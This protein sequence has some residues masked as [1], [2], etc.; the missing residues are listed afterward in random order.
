MNDIETI[1]VV[2]IIYG[3]VWLGR[4]VETRTLPPVDTARW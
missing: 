3:I 4:A 1:A 2:A